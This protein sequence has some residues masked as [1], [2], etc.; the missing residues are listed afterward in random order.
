MAIFGTKHKFF[1]PKHMTAQ[2]FEGSVSTYGD[3]ITEFRD[4]TNFYYFVALLGSVG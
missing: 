1:G 2:G 3:A 4:K